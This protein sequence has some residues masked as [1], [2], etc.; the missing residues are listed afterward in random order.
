MLTKKQR[1]L[2]LLINE[3]VSENGVP[4]SFD[5]MKVAMGVKSKSGIHRI[6]GILEERGFIKRLPHRAR[7]LEV[8]RLPD[9]GASPLQ[10]RAPAPL[11]A[12]APH[13][14]NP[15]AAANKRQENERRRGHGRRVEDATAPDF[16]DLT[17][18]AVQGILVHSN[19]RPLYANAALAKLFGYDAPS[20]IMN[21]PLVRPLIPPDMWAQV[22]EDYNDLV[23]GLK[24]PAITRVRGLKRDGSEIWLAITERLIEDWHG[25]RAVQINAFDITERMAAE[26]SLLE[27]EHRMRAMLEIL[28][29]PIYIARLDDAKLLF[30]NRKT[31]LLLQQGA[32]QLLRCKSSDFFVS[33]QDRENLRSLLET[34]HDIRDVEVN[35][36]TSHGREFVAELAAIK[37]DYGGEPAVLVALN[38]ISQRKQLEAELFQQANTDALT[39]ISNRRCFMSQAE[40]EMRRAQRFGRA[41]SVMMI[42][43]DNFKPINDSLG[44]AIGDVVLQGVVK[45]AL[46]SLRQSDVMGRLGGEEF[47]VLLPETGIAAA[48]DVANRLRAHVSSKPIVTVK[49][50]INC[51]VSVGVAQ[52]NGDDSSIDDLLRRA[53]EAM[54]RA[55]R[56]GRNRVEIGE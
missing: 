6:I 52:L 3:R 34:L 28:P 2:L 42:D 55:K 38:D 5:E 46:E 27:S 50:A 44:H 56:G 48:M 17:D 29:V 9:G 25:A 20:D 1:D 51:T 37:M 33:P 53:D 15:K 47:A 49:E 54:Y 8:I 18:N 4:P 39:G 40:Q 45:T 12:P 13:L 21:M 16:R 23:R 35:M 36:R 43:L 26:Q 10:R 41:L 24:K 14:P 19:F 11:A 31:C 7:A 22:E 32:G 30:V